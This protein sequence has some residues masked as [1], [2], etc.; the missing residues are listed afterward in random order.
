MQKTVFF[1]IASAVLLSACGGGSGTSA[2]LAPF[3]NFS[4]IPE[5]AFTQ[6][7]DGISQEV[8]F[9]QTPGG[10]VTD[11]S[12]ISAPAS[13]A[14][15]TIGENAAGQI[16]ASFSTTAGTNAAFNEAAGD[17][18]GDVG[19][20]TATDSSNLD[21][22]AFVINPFA[23]AWEYQTFGVWLTG[24]NGTSGRAAA[25]SFGASAAASAIPSSGNAT[26]SGLAAGVYVDAVGNA[27]VVDALMTASANFTD[28]T[29]AFSTTNTRDILAT[30]GAS[31]SNLNLNGTLT[32]SPGVNSFTGSIA[33]AGG[34]LAG[35]ATGRFYGPE[36][37]ELGGTFG[38][39]G[40][41]TSTYLGGF[42]G[43]RQ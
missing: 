26:Y 40:P 18:F 34:G 28:R 23:I 42:G 2:T 20:I 30:P 1:S 9:T 41:G 22:S 12:A 14:R 38:L 29:L 24:L 37:Q 10:I 35:T 21:R 8:G 11:V 7:L 32:Y 3:I 27:T 13:G 19:F 43:V 25:G 39:R 31:L 36:A 15:A 5:G 17:L 16:N 33:S 6:T 4:S